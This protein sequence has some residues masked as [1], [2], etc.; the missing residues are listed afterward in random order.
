MADLEQRLEKANQLKA[1][2]EQELAK[3]RQEKRKQ[4]TKQKIIAGA[5][6]INEAKHNQKIAD[7]LIKELDKNPPKS[8]SDQDAINALKQELANLP[9]SEIDTESTT[10]TSFKEPLDRLV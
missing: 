5:L 2:Y 4:E 3:I 8:K 6:V 7:W 10:Q 1:K 9:K